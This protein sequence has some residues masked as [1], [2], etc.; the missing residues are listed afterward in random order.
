M[1][2]IHLNIVHGRERE[3]SA[4]EVHIPFRSH[5]F[6]ISHIIVLLDKFYI[7]FWNPDVDIAGET[8]TMDESVGFTLLCKRSHTFLSDYAKP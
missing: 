1:E 8:K 3:E 5:N 2:D 7:R 6:D 4:H